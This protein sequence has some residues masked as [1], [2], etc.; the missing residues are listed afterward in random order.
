VVIT[1]DDDT[2]NV[3][4]DTDVSVWFSNLPTGLTA[5]VDSVS[6]DQVTLTVSGE[7]TVV[8]SFWIRGTI[9]GSALDSTT[10]ATI[11]ASESAVYDITW[12]YYDTWTQSGTSPLPNAAV[13]ATAYGKNIFVVGSRND[14]TG[15]YTI[16]CGA[17]WETVDILGANWVSIL[18]YINGTFYAGGD[19]GSFASSTDGID[20]T[21]FTTQL[22]GGADVR[23]IAYG[24]NVTVIAGTNSQAMWT[25]GYPTDSST[26]TAIGGDLPTGGTYNS[27]AFGADT[28][29]RGLFVITGQGSVSGY[30]YDGKT[31]TSTS[32]Q[33]KIIFPNTGG[34][35]SIKQVAYDPN[36]SKFVIV[37]YHQTAYVVP[38][39]ADF[40]WVGIDVSDIMGTTARTS[41]L[42]CVTYGGGYF[43]SGG[44][45][46]QT[47]AS[48]D[49][50]NWGITGV[51]G[52]FPAG[53]DVPFVNSIAFGACGDCNEYLIGGGQDNGPGIAAYNLHVCELNQ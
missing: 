46:G 3:A 9:P 27:I 42:N 22:L 45:E 43:V 33:T 24:N 13:N 34:Q 14:G 4:E 1:L 39:P 26:W 38:T 30:S 12:P 48:T 5:I 50:I 2:F 15:A 44:S 20:W 23:A 25:D 8:S 40:T 17:S 11:T 19:N 53:P 10:P 7:P 37:G 51:Q 21:P 49:G 35:S 16:D 36:Y 6:G 47:I 28:G 41:W 52:Q 32:D 29:G 31:W 18:V